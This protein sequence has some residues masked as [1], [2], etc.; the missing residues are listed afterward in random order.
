[1]QLRFASDYSNYVNMTSKQTIV[2]Q[3]I[4]TRCLVLEISR[5]PMW[6]LQIKCGTEVQ[7]KSTV[8][9][10]KILRMVFISINLLGISKG[11]LYE[12]S[13]VMV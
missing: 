3:L 10:K 4:F 7:N 1:M 2:L 11:L 6:I 8:C 12:L 5:Q 13:N 9:T